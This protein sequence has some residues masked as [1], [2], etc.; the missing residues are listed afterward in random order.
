MREIT[1]TQSDFFDYLICKSAENENEWC[2]VDTA[3]GE[4]LEHGDIETMTDVAINA[5]YL[6]DYYLED[7]DNDSAMAVYNKVATNEYTATYENGSQAT[8]SGINDDE[9]IET[10]KSE[11]E[12]SFGEGESETSSLTCMVKRTWAGDSMRI[13]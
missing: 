3:T 4:E 7:I 10:A 9:V 11:N 1:N 6:W 8:Y 5:G 12:F 13:F 2:I